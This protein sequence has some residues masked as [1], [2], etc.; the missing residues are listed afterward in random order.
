M[1]IQAKRTSLSAYRATV[2]I[3]LLRSTADKK[4]ELKLSRGH[5]YGT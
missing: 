2:P 1:E 3:F 4:V 5:A